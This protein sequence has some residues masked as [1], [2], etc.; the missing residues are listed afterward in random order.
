MA[1]PSKAFNLELPDMGGGSSAVSF[2]LCGA[3]KSGKTTLLKYLL[4]KFFKKHITMMF[5]MNPQAEIYKEIDDK[6]I[7]SDT[8]HPE[9]ISE[10]HII[11]QEMKNAFKLLYVS[12]DY[13]GLDIKNN[14]EITR[15]LTVL[16]NSNQSSIFSFQGRTLMNSVGRANCNY[17]VVLK[18][19]C[20]K[21]WENVIKD[22]LDM[23]LPL[24]MTMR[25][26]I[27]FCQAAT[28]NHQFFM[29]D[30]VKEECYISKLSA[31]QITE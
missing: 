9:L 6:I 18:Q 8:F 11:N 28:K 2:M 30:Q 14:K 29:I 22:F 5:T 19:Q 12:D 23:W 16:R 10:G 13:V 20:P 3:S 31:S 15:L 17:I 26:K 7:V 24:D 4:K 1:F 25:E 21:D 27:A